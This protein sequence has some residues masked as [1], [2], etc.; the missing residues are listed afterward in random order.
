MDQEVTYQRT[1]KVSDPRA[2]GG[3]I[4]GFKTRILKTIH[5][6]T[7]VISTN[8]GP[9]GLKDSIDPDD[10]RK[11]LVTQTKRPPRPKTRSSSTT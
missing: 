2:G 3:S 10:A 1:E 6:E 4:E 11:A 5:Y 7:R 9:L 8:Y